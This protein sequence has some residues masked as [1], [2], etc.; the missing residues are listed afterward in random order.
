MFHY[1]SHYSLDIAPPLYR[2]VQQ[3]ASYAHTDAPSA[4]RTKDERWNGVGAE[5]EVARV[6]EKRN[7]EEV[8]GT[9]SAALPPASLL[10]LMSKRGRNSFSV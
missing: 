8:G 9:Q 6:E 3:M 7:A 10:F 5:I 4:S 2:S 1:R